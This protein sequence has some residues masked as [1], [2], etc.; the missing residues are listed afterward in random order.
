MQLTET[1]L[2]A[3]VSEQQLA[4]PEVFDKARMDAE[5]HSVLL[6]DALIANGVLTE[7]HVQKMIADKLGI[8]TIDV[9]KDLIDEPVLHLIPEPLARKQQVIAFKREGDDLHVAMLDPENINVIDA[10]HKATNLKVVPYLTTQKELHDALA[11]YRKSFNEEY[12]KIIDTEVQKLGIQHDAAEHA[13][14]E[15]LKKLADDVPVIKIVDTII[16]QAMIQDASD[17]HIEPEENAL[18]VRF[19]IDGILR[20]T[21]TLSKK[22]TPAV[23]VRIKVLA[24]LRL[25]E[26][27][28]PQDGRFKKNVDGQDVSFRV[29]TLPTY[30]GEKVVIRLLKSTSHGFSLEAL[31]LHGDALEHVHSAMKQKTGLILVSGPTGSGKTTTLYTM[32]D[33]LNTTDV[34]ISTV[35]DPIE[36]Q[37]DRINQTQVHPD[38]GL[39]FAA[40]LRSL[41]RQDP[42][43][44]M[45]GEIRD[46]ETVSLAVNAALTG[47][48]VLS[49]IHTNS[50]AG[51]IPRMIDMGVEPFLLVSTI[52]TLTAQRLV[53]V[54]YDSR[55]EYMPDEQELNELRK[56]A[57]LDRVLEALKAEKI[58]DPNA[59]WSTIPF[60]KPVPT[61]ECESGYRGRIGIHEVLHLNENIK[62]LISG[63]ATQAQIEEQARND[64]MLTMIEDG[65]F[66]VAQGITTSAEVLRVVTE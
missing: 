43:I 34:N 8:P 30:F 12:E 41:L 63:S 64:G 55:E 58:V 29:S 49:T 57:N 13:T 38:I 20:D 61:E 22:I 53:R 56:I 21:A 16:S 2:R 19:R 10:I 62:Q 33:I 11:Q 44:I 59:D 48:L 5:Q 47:H 45:V 23:I 9:S 51:V 37:V 36:Y 66:K 35:E 60:Y 31:G 26:K 18:L 39:T 17:I 7:D 15:D 32:L 24:N 65:I 42:D 40:G 6:Q 1:E 14:E 25:D 27:R 28:L 54:L 46:K 3:F 52:K 4:P 50:A